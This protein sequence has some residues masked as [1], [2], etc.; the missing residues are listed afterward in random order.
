[1]IERGITPYANLYHYDLPLALEKK[2][3]GLLMVAA[4]GYDNGFFAP[5]RCSKAFGNCT[6]G[7]SATEPY[8]VAH[9]L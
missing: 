8:T 3:N 5:G 9:H 6:V 7:N 4:L 2:Y 1:M